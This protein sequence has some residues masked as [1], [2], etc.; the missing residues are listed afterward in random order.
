MTERT[1]PASFWI[2]TAHPVAFPRL[3]GDL[4]VDVAI[5]GG[6]MVGTTSARLL[7]DQGLTVAVVEG[8]KIGQGVTGRS[9]A[10]IT[11]QHNLVYGTLKTKFGEDGARLYAEANQAG[12]RT[13]LDLAGRHSLDCFMEPKAAFAYTLDEGRVGAIEAEAELTRRLGLPATLTRETPLPFPVRAALR[14]DDQAQF[15]PVDY[16]AGLAATIPGGGCHVF[17]DSRA[18]DWGNDRVA[19]AGGTLRAR[20]VVMATHLPPGKIGGYFDKTFP[21]MHPVIAGR[22]EPGRVPDGLFL[23]VETP[24]H[25]VRAHR[26]RDGGTWLILTG[27]AFAHGDVDEERAAFEEIERFA[28][29]HFG[30]RADYRWTSEDYT[31]A[32]GA[33]YVGWSSSG[34]D[35]W[36]VATGFNAWGITNGAAA[37][38]ILA[39]LLAGRDNAWLPVFDAS[40]AK[41]EDPAKGNAKKAEHPVGDWAANRPKALDALAAGDAAVLEMDGKKVAAFRDEAGGLHAVSAACT[42]MGCVLGWNETDRTWDCPCHGSRFELDGTV[43]HGPAVKPLEPVAVGGKGG[44]GGS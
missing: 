16:V 27:P 22:V 24:R 18:V 3:E 30:V 1:R 6:G 42:H 33:P 15:H 25:S 7:K 8:R 14:F 21:H 19:T 31:S 39:D 26:S 41:P 35:A 43:L 12:L 37:A 34:E 13:I 29:E 40:R 17:E 10:K 23:N 36:L 32:D 9:T 2:D 28:H 11:S 4:E 44:E 38:I 20:H 5:V